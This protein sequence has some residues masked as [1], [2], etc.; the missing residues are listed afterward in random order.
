MAESLGTVELVGFSDTSPTAATMNSLDDGV[1]SYSTSDYSGIRSDE[2]T[3]LTLN[4]V[5]PLILRRTTRGG[6]RRQLEDLDSLDSLAFFLDRLYHRLVVLHDSHCSQHWG[7]SQP[8]P[9]PGATPL[10]KSSLKLTSW[11]YKAASGQKRI[12]MRGLVGQT[13]LSG[14]L[15]SLTPLIYLGAN[16]HVG[17]KSS[18]GMGAYAV[19]RH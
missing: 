2:D 16:L 5:T 10:I 8:P 11:Y 19:T 18:F 3:T 9:L 15:G 14:T 17:S 4:F 6:S 7:D 13:S 12:D 1:L